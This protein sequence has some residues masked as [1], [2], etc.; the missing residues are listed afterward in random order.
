MTGFAGCFIAGGGVLQ[1]T[2]VTKTAATVNG[3]CL[4][5]AGYNKYKYGKYGKQK[6]SGDFHPARISP[7][8]KTNALC[9]SFPS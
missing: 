1:I 6:K 4:L 2:F 3:C 8:P 7:S 5:R 9:A